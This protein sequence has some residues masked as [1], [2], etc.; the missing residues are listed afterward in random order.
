MMITIYFNINIRY[1]DS[2]AQLYEHG[3]ILLTKQ[4]QTLSFIYITFHLLHMTLQTFRRAYVKLALNI[5]PL[6]KGLNYTPLPLSDYAPRIKIRKRLRMQLVSIYNIIYVKFNRYSIQHQFE[7]Q[8]M[9]MIQCCTV[10]KINCGDDK[11]TFCT[12]L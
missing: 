1:R 4:I 5:F 6:I 8:S 2:T 3:Q 11:Y 9:M 7:L 10:S 12:A